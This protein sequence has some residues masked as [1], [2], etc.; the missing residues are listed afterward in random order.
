ML[1]MNQSKQVFSAF[2]HLSS[3]NALQCGFF[4]FSKVLT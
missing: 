1:T 3:F 2:F 4:F